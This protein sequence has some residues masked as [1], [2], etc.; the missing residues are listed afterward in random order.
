MK[1]LL[2]P[3]LLSQTPLTEKTE[4]KTHNGTCGV[5]REDTL[6]AL[7]FSVLH[8]KRSIDQ[9]A[10]RQKPSCFLPSIQLLPPCGGHVVLLKGTGR[11]S[12]PDFGHRLSPD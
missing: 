12:L 10:G 9:S 4:N 5:L 11:T 6:Y 8:T 2:F 1:M 3:T 7:S